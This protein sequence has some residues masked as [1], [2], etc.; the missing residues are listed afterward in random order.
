MVLE[1]GVVAVVFVVPVL[2]GPFNL[3]VA[4]GDQ[5]LAMGERWFQES[6]AKLGGVGGE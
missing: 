5:A 3:S 2:L 4:K 6:F 1:A